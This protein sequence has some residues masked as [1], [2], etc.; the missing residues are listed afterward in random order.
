MLVGALL[1]LTGCGSGS[2]SLVPDSGRFADRATVIHLPGERATLCTGP[3]AESYPPQCD[4]IPI[5]N[6][7]WGSVP[8]E[9]VASGVRWGDYRVEGN[10]E[11]GEFTLTARPEPAGK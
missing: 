6:W 8:N 4:G 9:Q 11:E 10:V 7:D 5:T 3:V 1:V 2:Q